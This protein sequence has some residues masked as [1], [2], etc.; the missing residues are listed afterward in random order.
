VIEGQENS[1]RAIHLAVEALV[2]LETIGA[3][4]RLANGLVLLKR[5]VI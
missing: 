4:V 5:E 3:D 1:E 2:G